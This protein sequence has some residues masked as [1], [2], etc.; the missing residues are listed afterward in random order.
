MG[1]ATSRE[2]QCYLEAEPVAR[3]AVFVPKLFSCGA[4]E[5]VS[6][7]AGCTGPELMSEVNV[8]KCLGL[9]AICL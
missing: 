3:T 1:M 8:S 4:R 7:K 6:Q 9:R 5:L 2:E